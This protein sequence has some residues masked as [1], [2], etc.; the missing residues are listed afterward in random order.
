[1]LALTIDWVKRHTYS[2]LKLSRSDEQPVGMRPTPRSYESLVQAPGWAWTKRVHSQP[3]C[4]HFRP[5]S[6]RFGWWQ[7]QHEQ[8]CVGIN[9]AYTICIDSLVSLCIPV[10]NRVISCVAASRKKLTLLAS[11][12]MLAAIV[13]P[14]TTI[15]IEPWNVFCVPKS[16]YP[17]LLM[18]WSMYVGS[19][20][21]HPAVDCW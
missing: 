7:L 19:H 3:F 18:R 13:F 2:P 9:S 17:H 12:S 10:K 14:R 4:V 8:Y 16:Q 6:N 21:V 11:T 5:C 15:L 20:L 1:M